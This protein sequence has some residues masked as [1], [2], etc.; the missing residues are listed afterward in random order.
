MTKPYDTAEKKLAHKTVH[1]TLDEERQLCAIAQEQ[2]YPSASAYLRYLV[3]SDIEEKRRHF[4][5]LSEVFSVDERAV[6][7]DSSDDM[8]MTSFMRVLKHQIGDRIH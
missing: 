2:G 4:L 3:C 7:A 8:G 6:R 5:K 1:L